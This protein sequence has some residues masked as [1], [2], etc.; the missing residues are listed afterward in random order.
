LY[1][2]DYLIDIVLVQLILQAISMFENIG[3]KA[4]GIVSDGAVKNHKV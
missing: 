4:N 3:A 2:F 1:S